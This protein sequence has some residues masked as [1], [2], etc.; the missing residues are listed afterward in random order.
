M[1]VVSQASIIR[2]VPEIE[3][4]PVKLTV[5]NEQHRAPQYQ[6]C[7]MKHERGLAMAYGNWLPAAL[8]PS[9]EDDNPFA[10][11]RKQIDKMIDDFDWSVPELERTVAVRSN[12]SETDGEIRVTAEL[13]G[14]TDKDVDVSVTGDLITIKGE[15]KSE[16]EEKGEEEG[17]EFHRVERMSGAFHRALRM[18]FDID[19]DKVEADVKNGILTVTIPK[20]PEIAAKTKKIEVKHAA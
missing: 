6:T 20:P 5:V 19:A 18:P 10:T 2:S 3:N 1:Q 14:L 9:S 12:V 17:R 8:K 11:L 4:K 16:R 7:A 13:P 15:K